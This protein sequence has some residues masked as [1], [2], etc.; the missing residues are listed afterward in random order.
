MFVFILGT[1]HGEVVAVKLANQDPD[2]PLSVTKENVKQEAKLF[3]LLS[4]PNIILLKGVCLKEPNLCLV[5][6]YAHGGS[7]NRFLVQRKLS[8][9]VVVNWA[10]Q[11][12]KGMHYLHDKAPMALIHRDLKSGNS[13]YYDIFLQ[14]TP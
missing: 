4:H 11:I 10:Q 2:E 13:K 3:W 14:V 12:A 9:D 6:E 7:V 8:A 1:W 5:M